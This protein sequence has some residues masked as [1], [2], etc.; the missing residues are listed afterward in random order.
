[1]GNITGMMAT[2]VQERDPNNIEALSTLQRWL[3]GIFNGVLGIAALA[4]IC[5][6]IW[7]GFRL[8]K[9]TEE[10][11]RTQAKQQ[12]LWTVIGIIAIIILIV[13]INVVLIPALAA[14]VSEVNQQHPTGP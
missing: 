14:E 5:F 13:L 8:A 6:A 11:K 3:S 4:A 10:D 7:I 2:F 1:M 12:L 9:A